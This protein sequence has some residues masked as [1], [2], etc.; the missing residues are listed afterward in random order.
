MRRRQRQKSYARKLDVPRYRSVVLVDEKHKI[1]TQTHRRGGQ[2]LFGSNNAT[3]YTPCG[4]V[5]RATGINGD[6]PVE[7]AV[8]RDA[9]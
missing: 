9:T 7:F 2:L 8:R 6:K 4:S 1:L 3:A 5:G